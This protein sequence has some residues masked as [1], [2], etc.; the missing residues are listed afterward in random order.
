MTSGIFIWGRN[1]FF[2]C[3]ITAVCNT[4]LVAQDDR[5]VSKTHATGE[6][7]VT[8]IQPVTLKVL[9]PV[10]L[11]TI[12]E[13]DPS[14]IQ[15]A[16]TPFILYQLSDVS[17]TEER[18]SLKKIGSGLDSLDEGS[19]ELNI[20]VTVNSRQFALNDPNNNLRISVFNNKQSSE[21]Y[22]STSAQCSGVF[23]NM[24]FS[25]MAMIPDAS[26]AVSNSYDVHFAIIIKY[27]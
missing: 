7:L 10:K 15:K 1:I 22:S 12:H 26:E 13:S 27:N 17:L 14:Y 6:V 3:L 24:N 5:N 19:L 18:E 8:L 20:S 11:P 16:I 25:I 9:E 4:I 23:H 2:A 21:P